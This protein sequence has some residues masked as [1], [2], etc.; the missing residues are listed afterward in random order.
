M[1]E[2]LLHNFNEL[3]KQKNEEVEFL[4][5]SKNKKMRN[6]SVDLDYDSKKT[7]SKLQSFETTDIQHRH[8]CFNI[9]FFSSYSVVASV[10]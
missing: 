8:S 4:L 3:L 9:S 1:T 7:L 2:Q 6:K 5:N 10:L